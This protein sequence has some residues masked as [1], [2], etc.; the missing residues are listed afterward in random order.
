MFKKSLSLSLLI[1]VNSASAQVKVS[2]CPSREDVIRFETAVSEFVSKSK[3]TVSDFVLKHKGTIAD[4][5]SKHQV[6]LA[7]LGTGVAVATVATLIKKY[8]ENCDACKVLGAKKFVATIDEQVKEIELCVNTSLQDDIVA[9]K[10]VSED[11]LAV[12]DSYKTL[13]S[14]CE[15]C[16]KQLAG[17]H[18]TLMIHGELISIFPYIDRLKKSQNAVQEKLVELAKMPGFYE[19]CI[20]KLER[21]V[22]SLRSECGSLRG[23][24][25]SL[26][27]QNLGLRMQLSMKS[28]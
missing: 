24:I 18:L 5:V 7:C 8:N 26:N 1:L 25:S 10:A 17:A 28:H 21:T 14:R 9:K 6:A 23:Q 22:A 20:Q 19:C 16:A 2:K 4:F 3:K 27:C 15:A 11:L 12:R 13:V